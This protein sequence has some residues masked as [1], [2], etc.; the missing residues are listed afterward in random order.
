MKKVT[1]NLFC[2]LTA[3]CILLSGALPAYA[4]EISPF[5]SVAPSTPHSLPFLATVTNL[6]AQHGTYTRYYFTPENETL[7]LSGGFWMVGDDTTTT[8]TVKIELYKVGSSEVID[9]RTITSID[10]TTYTGFDVR[11]TTLQSGHYYLYIKNET[12]RSLV[13]ERW[14]SGEFTIA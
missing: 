3:I 11:F 13:S 10:N 14:V 6:V 2:I 1:T 7:R 5:A 9:S 12:S 8:R 4:T